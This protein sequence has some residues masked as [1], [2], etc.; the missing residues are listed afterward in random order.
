MSSS[1]KDK[2]IGVVSH[3]AGGA[4]VVSSYIKRNRLNCIYCLAGPAVEIFKKKLGP[5]ATSSLSDCLRQCDWLLCSMGWSEHEWQALAKAKEMGKRVVVF[6]DHWTRYN[7]RFERNGVIQLPNE[8]WVGDSSA[9][10]IAHENFSNIPIK[11]VPNPYYADLEDELDSLS[12]HIN[13][14]HAGIK[15][16]YVC[17]P[18]APETDVLKSSGYTDHEALHYF[19]SCLEK[20]DEEIES[21]CIRPHPTETK[22]KYAWAISHNH[23]KVTIGGD[24]SL[25]QEIVE[26]DWVVGRNSMALVAG[27][28]ANKT[29]ISCIPP[30]GKP[31]VLPQKEILHLR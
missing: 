22:D 23:K 16:L 6:L 29:V 11:L 14:P 10:K 21:I 9:E 4:E 31:C 27:L 7:D 19:F 2:C 17:E 1:S 5:I 12:R 13:I 20:R 30:N 8:L 26:N 3:D 28:I 25:L 15:I 18:T 24:R